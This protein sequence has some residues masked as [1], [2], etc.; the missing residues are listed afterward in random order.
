MLHSMGRR[1]GH[2]LVTEQQQ[3]QGGSVDVGPLR[4]LF[5]HPCHASRYT[6]SC[7]ILLR[8]TEMGRK[9]KGAGVY[10]YV[11]LIHFGVQQ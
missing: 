3:Q 5:Q 11:W 9:S 7:I 8:V 1:V 4:E 10:V 2:D 6:F